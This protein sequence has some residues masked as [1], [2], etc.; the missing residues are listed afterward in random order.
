MLKRQLTQTC[1]LFNLFSSDSL[2]SL[3]T[4]RP[5]VALRDEIESVFKRK[6][7]IT[8]EP[9]CFVF[10]FIQ[11]RNVDRVSS[12][13]RVL[14]SL[15]LS[16]R[17]TPTPLKHLRKAPKKKKVTNGDDNRQLNYSERE[18]KIFSLNTF[19]NTEVEEQNVSTESLLSKLFTRAWWRYFQSF[20]VAQLFFSRLITL[21]FIRI[22]SYPVNTC[23]QNKLRYPLDG[24]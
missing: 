16:I 5:W 8:I 22:N 17:L 18:I 2:F 23:W 3:F 13:F 11:G 6:M 12:F 4:R 20:S 19:R 10:N 7:F 15:S 1:F 14:Y 24:D 9:Y 21:S